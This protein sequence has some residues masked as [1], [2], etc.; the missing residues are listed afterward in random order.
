MCFEKYLIKWAIF[1]RKN[2]DLSSSIKKSK[3]SL[4]AEIGWL[5]KKTLEEPGKNLILLT[6]PP[7]KYLWQMEAALLFSFK[8]TG[9]LPK[10]RANRLWSLFIPM[11]RVNLFRLTGPWNFSCTQDLYRLSFILFLSYFFLPFWPSYLFPF[12]YFFIHFPLT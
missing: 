10:L 9:F 3:F 6:F 12:H 11:P 7:W 2:K 5:S 8:P 4:T 1:S